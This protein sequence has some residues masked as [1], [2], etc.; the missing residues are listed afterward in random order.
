[1][2]AVDENYRKRRI[3]SRLVKMALETMKNAKADEVRNVTKC[4]SF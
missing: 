1:M 4:D 2:L 3:G